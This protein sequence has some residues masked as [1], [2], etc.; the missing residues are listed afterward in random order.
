VESRTPAN[1]DNVLSVELYRTQGG[2]KMLQDFVAEF[3][4]DGRPSL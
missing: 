2:T 1:A 4:R 3:S